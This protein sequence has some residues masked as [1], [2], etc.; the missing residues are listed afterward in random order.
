M[1]TRQHA[2]G[3]STTRRHKNTCSRTASDG[4]RSRGFC[5]RGCGGV[6][7]GGRAVSGF[8]TFTQANGAPS[9]FWTSCAPR[10]W[11]AGWD[12][13]RCLRSREK[14]EPRT[15]TR[16]SSA[17][18][19]VRTRSCKA[20]RARKMRGC[21]GGGCAF[22]FLSPFLLVG[23]YF[24]FRSSPCANSV[25]LISFLPLCVNSWE[26]PGGGRRNCRGPSADCERSRQTANGK[27]LYIIL[28]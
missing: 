18:A 11:E 24:S 15:R 2:G 25:L 1:R 8:E 26:R 27:G 12:R 19:R 4:R 5:G 10:R 9:R 7:G 13:E 23:R 6:R 16:P 14:N 21:K 17:E 28:P 22:P 20:G 3:V